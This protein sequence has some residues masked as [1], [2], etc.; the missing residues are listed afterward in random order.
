MSARTGYRF[1]AGINHFNS[2]EV[3]FPGREFGPYSVGVN[4]GI[5]ENLFFFKHFTYSH[6][7][8]QTTQLENCYFSTIPVT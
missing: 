3:I 6:P 5:F 7:K 1:S 8:P 2:P 4:Q